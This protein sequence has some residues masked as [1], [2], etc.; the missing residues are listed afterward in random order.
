M[1]LNAG[2]THRSG[3][4]LFAARTIDRVDGLVRGRRA[5]ARMCRRARRF[6]GR[7]GPV[8]AASIVAVPGRTDRRGAPVAGAGRRRHRADYRPQPHA[9]YLGATTTSERSGRTRLS[10]PM[11]LRIEILLTA[12]PRLHPDRGRSRRQLAAVPRQPRGGVAADDPA[13]PDTWSATENIAWKIDVP[14]R[15][16]SSPIVWGDHVFVTAAVNTKRNRGAAQTR[17]FLRGALSSAARC[18][19]ATSALP[20]TR[21]AGSSPTSI[22]RRGKVRW[23]STVHTGVPVEPKH[24]KNSYASETPATDGERVLRTP[25]TPASSPST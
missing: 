16:W 1:D 19:A 13:L 4:G 3:D 12:C 11:K 7:P 18:P 25:A 24:Q 20:P 10:I 9:L 6:P 5:A 21:T 2:Y 8:G 14:G 23:Q 15:G 22:S 17:S